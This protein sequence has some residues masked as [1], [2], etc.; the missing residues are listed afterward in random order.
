MEITVEFKFDC[1][2]KNIFNSGKWDGPEWNRVCTSFFRTS[3]NLVYWHGSI[4]LARLC[5]S[6]SLCCDRNVLIG[7][8]NE[9]ESLNFLR[10]FNEREPR[11]VPQQFRF[12]SDHQRNTVLWSLCDILKSGNRACFVFLKQHIQHRLPDLLLLR[13]LFCTSDNPWSATTYQSMLFSDLFSLPLL[14]FVRHTNPL[15]FTFPS[16]SPTFFLHHR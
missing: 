15:L 14:Q 16:Y 13:S 6:I 3:A 2:N 11:G 5:W 4:P 1:S 8:S 7:T 9:Y 12:W 10:H